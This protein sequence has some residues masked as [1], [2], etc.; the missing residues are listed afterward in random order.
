MESKSEKNN[1][2]QAN[3]KDDLMKHIYDIS[4]LLTQSLSLDDVLNEIVD[5]VITGLKYDRAI[6]ML[7][8]DDET[9]LECKCIRGF[10]QYGEKRAWEKP[11][12]LNL[13]DCYETRVVRSGQVLF[14]P[15]IESDPNITDIDRTIARHQERRSLLHVPLKVKDK[16]L[17]TIGVDRYRTRMDISQEEVE[18]LAIFANQ[19]A[20]IIENTRLYEEIKEQ[21]FLFQNIT[22]SSINGIIVSDF[23][24]NIYEINPMAEEILGVKKEDLI[25]T[26]IEDIL[27]VDLKEIYE[28]LG[29]KENIEHFEV[30]YLRKDGHRLIL[31]LNAFPIKD[32]TPHVS[33]AVIMVKDLTEK[34]KLHDHLM[35]IEKFAALGSMAA[36]VAHE[37]RN[38]MAAI[39][40]TLQNIETGF[41][42]NSPKKYALQNVMKEV[43]RV[44]QLIR[45]LLNLS[46]S[47]PLNTL[48][49]DIYDLLKQ[50]IEMV[51]KRDSQ[52]NIIFELK[53]NKI[54]TMADPNRLKQVFINIIINAI[55]SISGAGKINITLVKERS[56]NKNKKLIVK[57]KDN[58]K[59]INPTDMSKIFDPFFSTKL[60][61]TGLGLTV[62]HKIIQDHNGLMEIESEENKGTTVVL[63][64]PLS[65]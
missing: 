59:G 36:W 10:T 30:N 62:S 47:V 8:N 42:D 2:I 39:Y 32:N 34:R 11:L 57:F 50:T 53:G 13:H 16:V 28:K 49:V 25:S 35:R 1:Q 24:G 51:R 31:D 14:I 37:I 9:K 7:L 17:G 40:T 58:G 27:K 22:D 21:K 19:A 18:A 60:H 56:T 63:R 61:G 46:I 33:K 54:F 48:R 29:Q 55:E 65:A 45:E 41:D 52:K 26:C 20:I 3:L 4:C 44:E 15:D 43:D 6:I 64:L 23:S 38:P 12:L 5:H